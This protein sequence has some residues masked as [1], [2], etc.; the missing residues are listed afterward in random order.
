MPEVDPLDER[1]ASSAG[2]PALLAEA[3]ATWVARADSAAG[4]EPRWRAFE[5][6]FPTFYQFTNRP[7]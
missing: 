5:D 7:R 1:I 3:R 4:E 2:L 6:A